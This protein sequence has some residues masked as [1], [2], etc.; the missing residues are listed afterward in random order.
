MS[1]Y[2]KKLSVDNLR[3]RL[4]RCPVAYIVKIYDII[5]ESRKES[6]KL[7]VRARPRVCWHGPLGT[8][9]LVSDQEKKTHLFFL[10]LQHIACKNYVK[11]ILY[12]ARKPHIKT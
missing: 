3:M 6:G 8:P 12:I 2:L 10:L 9:H 5:K 11:C 4:Y 1:Q 7:F